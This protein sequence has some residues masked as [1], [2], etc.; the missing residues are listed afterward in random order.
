MRRPYG[1][2]DI[3]KPALAS[4]IGTVNPDGVG[5]LTDTTGNRRFR[6]VFLQSIDRRY[7]TACNVSQIWAEAVAAY[8]NGETADLPVV[9]ERRLRENILPKGQLIDI[10]TEMIL[11]EYKPCPKDAD[12]KLWRK[13]TT[14]I[15]SR[16]YDRK[17]H[18]KS[19]KADAMELARVM[20]ALGFKKYHDENERGYEGIQDR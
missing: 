11:E 10:M 7:S 2:F 18:G 5:F 8:R 4:F 3:E 17:Y 19:T 15:L 1:R 6:P 14:Q 12:P 16:L 20:T 13:T 9:D